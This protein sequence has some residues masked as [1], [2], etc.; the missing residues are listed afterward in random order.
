MRSKFYDLYKY[1]FIQFLVHLYVQTMSLPSP[2]S[3]FTSLV[4]VYTLRYGISYTS[5][6]VFMDRLC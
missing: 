6:D 4:M 5:T 2:L 3:T 1:P